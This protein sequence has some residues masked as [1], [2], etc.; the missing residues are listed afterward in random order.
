MGRRR[1]PSEKLSLS[2]STSGSGSLGPL[3]TGLSNK[4]NNSQKL[5]CRKIT[6]ITTAITIP[7]YKWAT[8]INSSEKKKNQGVKKWSAIS[9]FSYKIQNYLNTTDE[10]PISYRLNFLKHTII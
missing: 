2:F 9:L 6:L 3:F 7:M 10:K 4:I 1:D 8:H 5:A